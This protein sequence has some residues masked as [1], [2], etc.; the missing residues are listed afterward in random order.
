MTVWRRCVTSR[1]LGT[2]TAQTQLSGDESGNAT[3]FIV[4]ANVR[5]IIGVE[6][7]LMELT[8]TAAKS[9]MATLKVTSNQG[10]LN[11][12]N[13]EMLAEPLG[14]VLGATAFQVTTPQI[15]NYY[16]IN[17]NTKGGEHVQ[18]YGQCQVANTV[19]PRMA[20]NVI[21]SDKPTPQKQVFY[22]TTSILNNASNPTSTGT[23]AGAVTG[24]AI[25]ITGSGGTTGQNRGTI[26]ALYG[27]IGNTTIVASDLTAGRFTI[28]ANELDYANH[29]FYNEPIQGFLGSTGQTNNFLSKS[30]NLSIGFKLPTTISTGINLDVAPANAGNFEICLAYTV[31]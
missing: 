1:S 4:P 27:A 26:V 25:T 8:P 21:M 23:S 3:D 14:A 9:V 7:Y 11:F 18:F 24:Q 30:L 15:R 31:P 10:D 22:A 6:P 5:S 2:S 16:P 19:G 17:I 28:T 13:C 29:E 12:G 20:A